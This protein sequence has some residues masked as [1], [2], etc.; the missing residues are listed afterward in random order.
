MAKA[1]RPLSEQVPASRTPEEGTPTIELRVLIPMTLGFFFI[2]AILLGLGAVVAVDSTR[3]PDGRVDVTVEQ[4]VLGLL[5]IHRTE[6]ADVV[7]ALA[8]QKPSGPRRGLS[9]RGGVQLQ[10]TLRDGT[11][12]ESMP[13]ANQIVGTPP[14]EMAKEMQVFI[15]TPRVGEAAA[16]LSLRWIPWLMCALAVP[17]VLFSM[18]FAMVWVNMARRGLRGGAV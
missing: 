17:F 5:T 16:T 9:G 3:L 4:R 14:N 6:L 10:L 13:A 8:V 11:E 1:A 18:L 2:T 15:E 7:R 12:W